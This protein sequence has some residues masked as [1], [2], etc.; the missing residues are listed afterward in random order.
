[1]KLLPRVFL[2][3]GL[4]VVAYVAALA[5]LNHSEV[6]A[7]SFISRVLLGALLVVTLHL[8]RKEPNPRNRV[9]FLNFVLFFSIGFFQLGTEFIGISLFKDHRYA[10]YLYGQY[11]N[12]AYILF[13]AIAIVYLV[14]DL[15]FHDFKIYQKYIVT[16]LIVLTFFGYYFQP[17]LA[18]PYYV[19][20][21][22]EIRQWK[23]LDQYAATVTEGYSRPI[24]LT[25]ADVANQV[26]L[27]SW[28]NGVA[29]GELYPEENLRRIE[30]LL[31]YLEG[32]NFK[33]L[34]LKPLH[35]NLIRMYVLLI[36][37]ILLFFGYQYKK[38][39][40]QG[41]YI[42]KIM[43]LLLM[44]CS[45]D[46]LHNWGFIKSVEWNSLTEL[47]SIGQYITILIELLMVLFFAMRLQF[48]TS[49]QGEF[50]ETELATNPRQISRWRDWVD[51]IVLS[52][53]FNFKLFNGRLFQNPSGK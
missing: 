50:Y 24:A 52:H 15:L 32:D 48:I 27:Q 4:L 8:V 38:D 34:L 33:A 11:V 41:A 51:N 29:I 43:F 21:T 42:D 39:P 1:M 25:A 45:M 22:E 44:F 31:P 40:P 6:L 47:Y 17:F 9:I 18:D 14:V 13:I 3:W 2:I 26:K 7:S 20:T 12:I 46:I 37:S 16:C 35:L 28:Q 49:V 10:G 53:F 19:Y 30:A 36:G 5:A 23:T